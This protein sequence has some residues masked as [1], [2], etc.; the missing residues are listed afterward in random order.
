M[1]LPRMVSQVIMSKISDT[2]SD[3]EDQNEMK[4]IESEM[5]ND[6]NNPVKKY[7]Y[8]KTNTN[9]LSLDQTEM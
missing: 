1:F 5:N 2:A 7:F 3:D 6:I 8:G 4:G 9:G